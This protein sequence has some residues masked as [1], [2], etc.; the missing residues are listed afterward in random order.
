M[1]QIAIRIK[2]RR[3]A[4]GMSQAELAEKCG[5]TSRTSIA[6][7][8]SGAVDLPQSKIVAIADALYVSAAY[9]MGIEDSAPDPIDDATMR[10]AEELRNRPGMRMLFDVS[11]NCSEK[12]LID[13]ANIVSKFRKGED[14]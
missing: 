8:E 10:L 4:I 2:E 1:N 6:K 12:D 13:I 3:E 7:I 14:D 11:R 9:L 5:Y